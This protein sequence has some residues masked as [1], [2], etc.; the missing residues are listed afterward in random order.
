MIAPEYLSDP[1]PSLAV[2]FVDYL[3]PELAAGIYSLAASQTLTKNGTSVDDAKQPYLPTEKTPVTQAIEVRAPRFGLQPEWMHGFYPPDGSVGLYSAVLPHVALNR[4]T[5]PWERDITS[6]E[7]K[8]DDRL[9]WMA[10]LLFAE[11]EL[12]EDPHCFGTTEQRSAPEI[13]AGEKGARHP[14]DGSGVTL[15][16]VDLTANPVDDKNELCRTI[17]VD[18]AVFHALAPQQQELPRLT[19]LRRVNE[20]HQQAFRSRDEIV[21]GDYAVMVS[22]R[23][24]RAAGGRYVAHLV[25]LEGWLDRLPTSDE[26][27]KGKAEKLRLV[28]LWSAAFETLPDHSPG[29]A[30]LTE[31]FLPPKGAD[32]SGLLLAVPSNGRRAV[33]T[34][35]KEVLAR[36][37]DGYLPLACR[38]EWGRMTFGWYR[39]PFT[40]VPAKPRSDE[41]RR[42]CAAQ[43]LVYLAR[44]GIFDVSL[45]VAFTAGRGVALANREMCAALLRLRAKA[46]DLARAHLEESRSAYAVDAHGPPGD[47]GASAPGGGARTRLEALVTAGAPDLAR[48]WADAPTPA[49]RRSGAAVPV[50]SPP[51]LAA[52]LPVTARI[53]GQLLRTDPDLRAR[54]KTALSGLTGT[55]GPAPAGDWPERTGDNGDQHGRDTTVEGSEDGLL[56]RNW[57]AGLRRLEGVPFPHLVP[58][59]R[60]LPA[61]SVRFFYLDQDWITTA[62]E[63]ALSVG[64]ARDF[65][66]EC[67]KHLF[68]DLLAPSTPMT[69]LLIRSQLVTGWPALEVRPYL[70]AQEPKSGSGTPETP[71]PV[72]RREELARD[73]LLVLIDGVPGRIELAEPAQGLH[74]GIDEPSSGQTDDPLDD[75]VIR[76]RRLKGTVGKESTHQYPDAGTEKLRSLLR[77]TPAGGPDNVL[78]VTELARKLRAALLQHELMDPGSTSTDALTPSEFAIQMI[79]AA[80]RRTFSVQ[81]R[82][83]S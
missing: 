75:G 27:Y 70:A 34:E 35:Q 66:L 32:G 7:T 16:D 61:E 53:T 21:I 55:T 10:L 29:F 37:E 11:G 73:V 19:H 20:Q 49:A 8:P 44:Y 42:R 58:D 83:A 17:L 24:P 67:D 71:L 52:R 36:L 64:L 77:P 72:V 74:F 12:T 62:V 22:S 39:G 76:L 81:P 2:E 15:P 41:Q 13:T 47:R 30:A 82:P 23:L 14:G 51:P 79:N 69:G 3:V 59:A 43:A 48:A 33:G 9:P 50:V 28:S 68:K 60:M 54:L 45:A 46:H 5:L 1:D 78:K 57:L 80:Q 4:P 6:A 18:A 40:P 65:D 63:G 25:S 31:N 56:V 26:A 38:T